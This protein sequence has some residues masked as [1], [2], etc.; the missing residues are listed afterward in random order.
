MN[1]LMNE[2]MNELMNEWINEWINE[3]MNERINEWMNELM[4]E[5]M[6][7]WM[8]EWVNEWMN[9]W[10]NIQPLA[11]T[12]SSIHWRRFYFQLTRVHS[13]LE[14]FLRCA[15]QITYLFTYSMSQERRSYSHT[16]I[17]RLTKASQSQCCLSQLLTEET[18]TLQNY[19]LY[20][21]P[22]IHIMLSCLLIRCV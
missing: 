11:E 10:M 21:A 2:W 16:D 20:A 1:E 22:N 4:N 8:N 3:L 14:L 12:S 9:E 5:W 13:A 15:L 17:L 19:F 18:I 7:E 6:S